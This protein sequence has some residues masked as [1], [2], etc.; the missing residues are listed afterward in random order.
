MDKMYPYMYQAAKIAKLPRWSRDTISAGAMLKY[1]NVYH[2]AVALA[3]T[4][5]SIVQLP[6]YNDAFQQLAGFLIDRVSHVASQY[7]ALQSIIV[8]DLWKQQAFEDGLLAMGSVNIAPHFRF[9]STRNLSYY[10]GATN[11]VTNSIIN[12]GSVSPIT[13]FGTVANIDLMIVELAKMVGALE[14]VV[15]NNGDATANNDVFAIREA[16]AAAFNNPLLKPHYSQGLPDIARIPGVVPSNQL[17]N[18]WYAR[19]FT[20]IDSNGT[21][22]SEVFPIGEET[23][24]LTGR[25]I[26]IFGW[27]K[28]GVKEFT[29]F[30]AIKWCHVLENVA[31]VQF[32]ATLSNNKNR[33]M[34]C[35]MPEGTNAS[36]TYTTY[37]DAHIYTR[38][39]GNIALTRGPIDWN[40]GTACRTAVNSG[41]PLYNRHLFATMRFAQQLN[42]YTEFRFLDQGV[43]DF[44]MWR[45]VTDYPLNHARYIMESAGLPLLT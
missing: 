44:E 9:W 38:E 36:P 45:Q 23:A 7:V 27:G 31:A 10:G 39:D 29:L 8:P 3:V 24:L 12:D 21:G 4:L 25:Q 14:G 40:D 30:G 11:Y 37:N 43:K 32:Y 1:A 17:L 19:C 13:K 2:N 33:F 42:T 5:L 41:D 20:A 22:A 18:D 6:R 26:P 16:M 35:S 15:V 34:G 28:P